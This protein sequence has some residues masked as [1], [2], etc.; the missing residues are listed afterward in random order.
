MDALDLAA[1]L[2]AEEAEAMAGADA[3]ALAAL[4]SDRLIVTPPGGP[5][6]EKA[7]ALRLVE[8]G[9]LSYRAVERAPERIADH[10]DVLVS[11]GT[12]KVS[13]STGETQVRRYTHVWARE[14]KTWRL[15]ARHAS[16]C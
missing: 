12:E 5:R 10:G 11:M 6:A 14:S 4:W 3:L 2:D 15:L 7:T 9:S 13:P 8:G 1:A 16:P